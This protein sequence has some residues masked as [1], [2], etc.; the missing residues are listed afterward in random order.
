[1]KAN[2]IIILKIGKMMDFDTINILLIDDDAAYVSVARHLLNKFPGRRFNL[3]WK[4]NGQKAI[5]ELKT[6][7]NIQLILVDYYLPNQNGL[8]IVKEIS[9]QGIS[10]PIIF[11]TTHKNFKLAIEAMRY[12][13]EDY[14]IKDEAV[15][16]LLPRA[17]IT[18]L[19]RVK[20]KRQIETAEKAKMISEKKT[21]AI[22][23]LIVT[24]CHEFNNPLAAIR[25]STDIISRQKLTAEADKILQELVKN[26]KIIEKEI[27]TL[28]DIDVSDALK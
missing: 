1:M 13:V 9:E 7:P 28:R 16:T 27:L 17:I 26:L 11:L 5:A 2:T 6:N 25:I 4:E 18:V 19:E 23:E 24:I 14:L 15:D 21:E 3:I 10:V 12:N 8:E 22:R 20:I